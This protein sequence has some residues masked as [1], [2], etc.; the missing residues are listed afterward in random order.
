MQYCNSTSEGKTKYSMKQ[1]VEKVKLLSAWREK[2]LYCNM[3]H[4]EN[5]G[6]IIRNLVIF[7]RE[8]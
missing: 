6:H 4:G 7:K 8:F 1:S 2:I 3:R 5:V